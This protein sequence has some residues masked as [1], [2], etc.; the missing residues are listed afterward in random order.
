MQDGLVVA[1]RDTLALIHAHKPAQGTSTEFTTD[2]QA[3][4][5]HTC[6]SATHTRESREEPLAC[7]ICP[8]CL[9]WGKFSEPLGG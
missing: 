2:T 7:R 5:Q 4:V 3:A 1:H 9:C 8:W 6:T